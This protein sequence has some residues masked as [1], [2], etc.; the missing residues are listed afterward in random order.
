MN[1]KSKCFITF[2]E[3]SV[4][5]DRCSLTKVRIASSTIPKN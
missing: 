1:K 5:K 3:I 2:L 4:I